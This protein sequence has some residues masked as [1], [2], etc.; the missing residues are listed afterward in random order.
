[1]GEITQLVY[2]GTATSLTQGNQ[3]QAVGT[4]R[5]T[6]TEVIEPSTASLLSQGD[7]VFQPYVPPKIIS[8]STDY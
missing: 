8:P 3:V 5:I 2:S 1:M 4:T 6:R 7:S